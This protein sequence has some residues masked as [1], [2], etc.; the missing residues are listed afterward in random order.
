[1]RHLAITQYLHIESEKLLHKILKIH[2]KSLDIQVFYNFNSNMPEFYLNFVGK[3][4]VTR[5]KY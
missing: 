3:M 1:M 5:N 4:I 2:E